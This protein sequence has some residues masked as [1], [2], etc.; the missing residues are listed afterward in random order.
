[1]GAQ[2]RD[3]LGVMKVGRDPASSGSE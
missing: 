3:A 1:M 2:I